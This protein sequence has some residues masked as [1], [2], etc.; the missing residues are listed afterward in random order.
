MISSI[1]GKVE[2]CGQVSVDNLAIDG[3]DRK[4]CSGID[5]A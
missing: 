2:L 1:E 3:D 5:L 4:Y